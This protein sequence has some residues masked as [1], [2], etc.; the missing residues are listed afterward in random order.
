[1]ILDW[2]GG[3]LGATAPELIRLAFQGAADKLAEIA[4]RHK[5]ICIGMAQAHPGQ[6]RNKAKVDSTM[7]CECKTMGQR[8]ANIIGMSGLQV[9]DEEE[10]RSETLY[11]DKQYFYISKCRK[12][13]GGLKPFIREFD[14]QRLRDA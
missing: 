1:M 2:I 12:S 14:Y 10:Q 3:A 13:K 8:A 9:T 11:Q 6:S 7:L 4:L 5:V